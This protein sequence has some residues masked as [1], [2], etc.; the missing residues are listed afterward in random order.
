MRSFLAT[1]LRW[2]AAGAG[3][4]LACGVVLLLVSVLGGGH[5]WA[6]M[7]LLAGVLSWPAG[8]WIFDALPRAMQ[9]GIRGIELISLI[10]GPLANGAVLGGLLGCLAWF[11]GPRGGPPSAESQ[12]TA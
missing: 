5:T 10:A 1:V 3:L 11:A 4:G 7:L 8:L 2:S 6:G 12:G 9:T